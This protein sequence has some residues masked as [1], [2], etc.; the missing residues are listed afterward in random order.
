MFADYIVI[1]WCVCVWRGGMLLRC[2]KYL[3]TLATLE[4]FIVIQ[5][6][7]ETTT[8]KQIAIKLNQLLTFRDKKILS[9]TQYGALFIVQRGPNYKLMNF[10]LLNVI[11]K[12]Y[13]HCHDKQKP[14]IW[15]SRRL[16]Q[17]SIAP[18]IGSFFI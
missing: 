8:K 1:G 6:H 18:G 15:S 2:I 12:Y 3:I 16:L 14:G 9:E 7:K 5:F 4:G 13:I 10:F 17:A 11:I